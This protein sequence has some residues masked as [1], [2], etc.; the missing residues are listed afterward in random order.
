[1]YRR[2]WPIVALAL[3]QLLSPVL[4]AALNA[5]WLHIELAAYVRGFFERSSI[6]NL[7]VFAVIPVASAV[8]IYVCKLW[9]LVTFVLL[10]AFLFGWNVWQRSMYPNHYSFWNLAFAT[11]MN[12]VLVMYFLVPAVRRVYTNPRIRW[13]ESKPRYLKEIDVMLDRD[14]V[15]LTA[16]TV[17]LSEGG[18]FIRCD[19]DFKPE[20]RFVFILKDG[21]FDFS[22]PATIVHNSVGSGCYGVR[23]DIDNRKLLSKVRGY[24]RVLKN[25]GAPERSPREPWHRSLVMWLSDFRHPKKAI[26]PLLPDEIKDLEKRAG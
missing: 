22:T 4:N 11:A 14:G 10:E 20:D 2:P 18:A 19:H 16:R 23:F 3:L 9:G 21:V 25:S 26:F 12:L 15:A 5:S 6:L 7:V 8:S 24:M 1:M 13:W 17:N